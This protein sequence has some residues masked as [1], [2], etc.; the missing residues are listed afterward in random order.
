MKDEVKHRILRPCG[1]REWLRRAPHDTPA[2]AS[3]WVTEFTSRYHAA[4][5]HTFLLTVSVCC[6]VQPFRYVRLAP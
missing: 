1:S 4:Y 2:G 6:F 3:S 5:L